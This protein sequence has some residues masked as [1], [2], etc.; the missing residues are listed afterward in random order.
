MAEITGGELLARCL[1]NEGVKFI[2]GLPC[3]EIDPLLAALEKNDIRLVPIRHEAA[4]VHMAEGVYRT[5]GQVAAVLGNPGPGSANLLP[6]V[7]TARH[8]GVPVIVITSQHRPEIVY[9]SSPSTFQG[10]DQIDVFKPVVKWGAPIFSWGRIPEIVRMAYREMWLGRPGPVH[11]DV[12]MPIMY[13]TGDEATAPVFP[14]RQYRC[15]LP[16]PSEKQIQEAAELLASAERPLVISGSGVDRSG[17]NVA[18]MEIVE[19]LNCP[20]FSTMA[21]RSTVPIDHPNHIA[22]F[23]SG[24][25]VVKQEADVVLVAGSRLGNLDLPYDK[26]W[27]ESAKH[28]FIQIDI[29]PRNMGVT[30]PITLGIVADLS[31]TLDGLVKALKA[32]KVKQKD[33]KDLARYRKASQESWDREFKMVEDWPG[34]GIHP[35]RAMQAI[36]ETF[37]KDAIYLVDG[38][39]TSLWAHWFLPATWPRS[40]HGILE[41]GML[42]IGVP[43]AV[44]AKLANPDRKVVCVTG[45]GAA[46]FN[47]MEMQS[48]ARENLDITTVVFAEGQWTMEVPNE[49]MLYGKTFGTGMGEVRW[50]KVGEGLGCTGQYAEKAD[51]VGPALKAAKETTG[52][53]VVCL[54]TD[55]E[56]NLGVPED[57]MMRFFEVYQGPQ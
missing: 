40:Y 44:G 53:T 16:Q 33:G 55:L 48:A 35:A 29:D 12:P 28:K 1:A 26:Y 50:D 34:P 30:R 24:G 51:E 45:D 2:F 19:I 38:G 54:K 13:E 9:P 20:V 8:E 41:L 17:A 52:P 47:F 11:L 4:A 23:G 22:S 46:G 36:S 10:Q 49:M 37:G 31:P 14:P 15:G 27:G 21:G 43:Y 42:G 25:D 39:M 32:M 57:Y 5:S 18:L 3:P 7:I 6:G 56:A